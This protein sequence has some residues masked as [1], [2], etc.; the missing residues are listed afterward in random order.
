[1]YL[2]VQDY[3]DSLVGKE[4]LEYLGEAEVARLIVELGYRCRGAGLFRL[5]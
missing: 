2:V 4:D 1:M 3:L 5:C